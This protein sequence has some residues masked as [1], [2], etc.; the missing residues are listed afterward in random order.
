MGCIF[1]LP[2]Y[3]LTSGWAIN[4]LFIFIGKDHRFGITLAEKLIKAVFGL[5]AWCYKN[6]SVNSFNISLLINVRV[7][8][9]ETWEFTLEDVNFVQALAQI[10][11]VLIE[12]TRLYQGQNEYIEALSIMR[13]SPEL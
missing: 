3:F 2:L 7:Y 8:T 11:G 9:A 10:A 12:M 1:S 13:E 5:C 6:F 4:P